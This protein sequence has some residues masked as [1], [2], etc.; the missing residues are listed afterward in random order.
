MLEPIELLHPAHDIALQAGREIL[1]IYAADIEVT[2]KDDDSPLTQADL[3][4]H[5]CIMKGLQKLTPDI[6]ILS[7]EGDIPDF[8]VRNT[9][10]WYWII[11][12][13]DGTREFIK[14][15]GEFTVNIALIHDG[16]P[17]LG[18]VYAP[19][20]DVSY[21]AALGSGAWKQENDGPFEAIT[22]QR[23]EDKLRV[24]ASRSH[25]SEE[26]ENVINLLP[27]HSEISVGS[28]LKFCMVAEA[29]A[30]FYPRIGLTSEWDTAAGQCVVEQAGGLVTT[31]DF[32]PLR[33][34]T[35]ESLLNPY[36]LVFGDPTHHWQQYFPE[37]SNSITSA[38]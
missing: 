29:R 34:N 6:P 16:Q 24:V 7:E 19:A 11:D 4:S 26:L 28:S 20:L 27:D 13:L 5:H 32:Q 38:E 10:R 14:R 8:E 22:T 37:D 18:V 31:M 3:A 2:S 17:V 15:N 35:K 1:K 33:Y 12:P 25:R 36:F 23:V 9:W 21:F 30:D